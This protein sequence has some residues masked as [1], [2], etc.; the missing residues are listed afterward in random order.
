M[1]KTFN[2]PLLGLFLLLI[3][4]S[5]KPKQNMVY[6]EHDTQDQQ[7]AIERA[8][9]TGLQIQEGD[10]LE[11]NVNAFDDIAV[12][13]FN[14]STMNKTGQTESQSQTNYQGSEYTVN[15]DGNINFPVLGNIYA[16][17]MTKQQLMIVLISNR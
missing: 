13:P 14:I 10:V 1:M 2:I 12:R 17:G 5:C 6:L 8:K 11:I 3:I 9:Y 16:K 7:F 15:T 4:T